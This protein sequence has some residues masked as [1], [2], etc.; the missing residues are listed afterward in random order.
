MQTSPGVDRNDIGI[1]SPYNDQI[2]LLMLSVGELLSSLQL[3]VNTTKSDKKDNGVIEI[4]TA[5]KCQ[6]RDKPCIL[7]SFVRLVL[8]ES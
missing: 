4:L 1:I 5:D 8:C 2:D 7:I 3:N 6:G